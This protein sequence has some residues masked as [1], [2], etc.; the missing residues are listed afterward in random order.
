ME[1]SEAP[2][3]LTCIGQGRGE[4]CYQVPPGEAA[5]PSSSSSFALGHALPFQRT[6][7]CVQ[8][9]TTQGR[10]WPET[11]GTSDNPVSFAAAGVLC[12]PASQPGGESDTGTEVGKAC[13]TA[14]FKEWGVI[15]EAGAEGLG[16]NEG[17][18]TTVS[19]GCREERG[20]YAG[21]RGFGRDKTGWVF[22]K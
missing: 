1:A 11:S 22:P 2:L 16:Q 10:C 20:S 21:G 4:P 18:E 3:S 8:M 9:G 7:A 5:H 15:E 17:T 14:E 19:Q 6:W 12:S 13:C